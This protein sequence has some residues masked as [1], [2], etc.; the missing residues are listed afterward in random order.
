MELQVIL[1]GTPVSGGTAEGTAV[2]VD[3]HDFLKQDFEAGS[4]LVTE[5]TEPSMI[6]MMNKAAAIVTE[7]GG[8]TS[9]AAIVSR[10]LGI[11]CVTATKGAMTILSTGMRR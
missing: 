1:K 11:P 7:V 6:L 3:R 9:H 2:I 10:E 4:I 5:M 8:I